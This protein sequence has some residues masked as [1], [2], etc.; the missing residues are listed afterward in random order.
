M[1]RILQGETALKTQ[2]KVVLLA[3]I[4]NKKDPGV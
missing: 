1:N 4:L 3:E 2:K